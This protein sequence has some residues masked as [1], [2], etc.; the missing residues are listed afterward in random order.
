MRIRTAVSM[1]VGFVLIAGG[2]G[3]DEG[4]GKDV[5]KGD[6]SDAQ[7]DGVAEVVPDG[8]PDM[9]KDLGGDKG[10][11]VP[12]VPDV[13][14]L[15]PDVPL[16]PCEG[17]SC[18]EGFCDEAT[19]TC[20]YCDEEVSCSK[21]GTWCRDNWC[22]T[23]LC[24]PGSVDCASLTEARECAET[25][26]SF[27]STMCEEGF[28]CHMGQ[29]LPIICEAGKKEC[30]AAGMLKVCAPNGVAWIPT[31]CPPGQ[32]CTMGECRPLQHNLLVIFDTSSSM[33]QDPFGVGGVPCIC[34]VCENKPFPICEDPLCPKS[35]LGL[36][37]HVFNKFF[38]STNI[39]AVNLVLT[40]FPMRIKYPA[41][42]AC[43]NM[44][45]MARGYYG[46]G[47]GDSDFMTGD[48]NSH[49]TVDGG[50]FDKYLYEILSVP[51]P[52]D[53][54]EDNLGK[55]KLWVDFDEQVGPTETECV[56]MADCPGGFCADNEGKKVCWYHTNG[57]LRALSNTPLGRSM[58][59]AGEIYRKMIMVDG[60]ECVTSADCKNENY[61]CTVDGK[62]KDPYAD[63]RVN[64]VLMFTD[65]EESPETSTMDFFNPRV[66]AKRFRYGLKCESNDDCF[67]GSVCTGNMCRDYP[68]PNGGSASY[69]GNL[70]EPQR[71]FR[72]D[73]KPIKIMTHVIDMSPSGSANNRGIADDG[74]GSYYQATAAD[75]DALLGQLL[76]LVDVKQNMLGCVPDYEG[77]VQ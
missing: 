67:D 65:G 58:F 64:M 38:N 47:M 28:G 55:A 45:A 39:G 23:T 49:V 14:E 18:P 53:S 32:S 35:K 26:E 27:V 25:G 50:W 56:A 74:G 69:P 62:C 20:L 41:T 66:Q 15:V 57:E 42:T 63:C 33:A 13:V 61:Y 37:K 68:H 31:G 51:F 48:D 22:V 1:L 6:L 71:L 16:G 11:D 77:I 9:G 30:G 34:P 43:N 2:C 76:S 3:S 24:I 75:P 40:H 29:C 19:G 21:P 52:V 8:T 46:M 44:F 73:G 59:Y 36:S 54:Q 12:A 10:P 60:K 72:Y 70:E 7:G 5:L 4:G 17:T